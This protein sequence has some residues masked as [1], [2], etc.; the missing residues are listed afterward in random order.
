MSCGA[1]VAV[2]VKPAGGVIVL[3][4]Q[5]PHTWG[6]PAGRTQDPSACG[7]TVSTPST[8]PA[9]GWSG[10]ERGW[11]SAPSTECIA[12]VGADMTGVRAAMSHWWFRNDPPNAA[13]KKLSATT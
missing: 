6:R 2:G 5:S 12:G 4:A 1:N 7:A 13:W 11:P 8:V 9:A 3:I 10:Y